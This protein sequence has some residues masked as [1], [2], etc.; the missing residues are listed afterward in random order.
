MGK[1]SPISFIL[2]IMMLPSVAFNFDG[3]KS[4]GSKFLRRDSDDKIL[5]IVNAHRASN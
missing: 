1:N 5:E 3:G 2:K 4:N